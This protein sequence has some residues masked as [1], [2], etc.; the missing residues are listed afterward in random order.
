MIKNVMAAAAV[1]MLGT[2]ASATSFTLDFSSAVIPPVF[3][4]AGAEI[5]V[6]NAAAGVNVR[7][8]SL[9]SWVQRQ[10]FPNAGAYQASGDL[11]LSAE[12]GDT[13]QVRIEVF[14]A[15]V[16][17]G[18]D[19][20]YSVNNPNFTWALTF[21]D[22]DSEAPSATNQNF[23]QFLLRTAG[24]L[25]LDANTAL[26]STATGAG[27]IVSAENANFNVQTDTGV[28]SLTLDQQRY[29]AVY[30]LSNTAVMEFDYIVGAVGAT[31]AGRVGLIDGGTLTLDNPVPINVA[32]V[33]LPAS[34]L[35]LG[36]GVA[37]LGLMR[38]RTA[39]Q[40]A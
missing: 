10:G 4:N 14:D 13:A 35:L 16:G 32:P 6:D 5:F 33:P 21:Y 3:E 2:M 36:A 31:N 23:D 18:Y 25:F 9:N 17:S 38:R 24:T 20:L 37:G 26:T 39:R 12:E 11:G 40:A 30:E 29:A 28:T 27:L 19:Q 1:S 7:I 15:L 34:V 22:I 8:T